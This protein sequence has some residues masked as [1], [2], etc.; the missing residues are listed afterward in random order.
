M[1]RREPVM[2]LLLSFVT[3]GIYGI[4]WQYVTT[5]EL[6]DASGRQDLNP[7]LDLVVTLLC[8]GLWSLY[9]QYRNA[10]IIHEVL[11]ARG[12]A[13]EDKSNTVLLLNIA[14]F[15]TGVTGFI[16]PLILQDEY[17]KIAR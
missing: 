3:C 7:G 10:Q 15:V 9:V 4:Y 11:T 6:R 17:N 12:I 14:H 16:P 5:T 8:C 13:H 1:T 2:V